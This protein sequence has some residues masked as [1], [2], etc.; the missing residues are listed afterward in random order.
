MLT[1]TSQ[2]QCQSKKLQLDIFS[3]PFQ[4]LYRCAHV[5]ILVCVQ[6]CVQICLRMFI[7]VYTSVCVCVCV[8]VRVCVTCCFPA[9]RCRWCS[10]PA[11]SSA[12]RTLRVDPK[13]PHVG[14]TGTG[15]D[16]LTSPW[17]RSLLSGKD[18]M[19]AGRRGITQVERFITGRQ[20][21]DNWHTSLKLLPDSVWMRW[22]K[23]KWIFLH[24]HFW[25]QFRVSAQVETNKHQTHTC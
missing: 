11:G 20:T 2:S 24:F 1:I 9:C 6:V 15:N 5:Q 13:P 19:P 18:W 23:S 16:H 21:E 25:L 4:F 3:K 14:R 22:N 7:H 10:P 12:A 8:C 17:S